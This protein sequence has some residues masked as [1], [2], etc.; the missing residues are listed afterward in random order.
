MMKRFI[1]LFLCVVAT[2][3]ARAEDTKR[4]I[5]SL[6]MIVKNE[7]HVICRCLESVLPLIDYWVIVDTGSTDGTQDVIREYMAEKNI[8]GELYERPWVNFAYNRNEALELAR[9]SADYLLIM[10]ADDILTYTPGYK[11]PEVFTKDAYYTH[12]N[13]S[14]THYDRIQL[15]NTKVPFQWIGVVHEVL[16]CETAKDCDYL[17][18]VTM[19]IIGGGGRS[20]D[21]NKFL[22]D[23]Q[24]LEADL[25]TDPNNSRTMFY[26]AQS[27]RDANLLSEALDRYEKRVAMGGWNEEVF[28]SLYQIAL[29]QERLNFPVNTVIASYYKA[30][31]YRPIR[32]ESL[33]RIASLHRRT[34]HPQHGLFIANLALKIAK[35]QDLIFVE[36]W[37]YDYGLL[38]EYSL[39]A[40][41]SGL[42][43][44][45]FNASLKLLSLPEVPAEMKR[46][47]ENN[48][49]LIIQQMS[50]QT[51]YR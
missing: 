18:G 9:A 38:F 37:L 33:Y 25:L 21:P 14:G 11:R 47:V 20:R 35:P 6:N 5:V 40:A 13:Y 45:A 16:Y 34:G 4:S 22:K 42:Y 7:A 50:A 29:I 10:D 27:Y 43:Q 48:I 31:D 36:S 17:N 19:V 30:F 23:A 12:I 28:W 49:Q 26:L 24:I 46:D 2:C 8:P 3:S 15:I 41:L 32:A 39:C 51:A 44:E 1:L